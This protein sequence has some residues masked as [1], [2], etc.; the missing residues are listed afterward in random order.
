MYE[1][2]IWEA[3][4]ESETPLQQGLGNKASGEIA[5]TNSEAAL[6][7]SEAEMQV[8]QFTAE[9]DAA[10]SEYNQLAGRVRWLTGNAQ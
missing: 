2:N 3:W 7:L 4:T 8:Q 5:E 9:Q 1:Q 10:G 6:K